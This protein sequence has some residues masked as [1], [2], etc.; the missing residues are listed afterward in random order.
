MLG[1]F[2]LV[3]YSRVHGILLLPRSQSS[4]SSFTIIM[5]TVSQD[6][7]LYSTNKYDLNLVTVS[8]PPFIIRIYALSL[9]GYTVFSSTALQYCTLGYG[10]VDHPC[11]VREPV[12]Y[13]GTFCVCNPERLSDDM[14]C[15]TSRNMNYKRI[16]W[17]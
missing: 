9:D 4:Y 7:M 12:G 14:L 13:H 11:E 6:R 1:L 8:N 5:S 17:L 15:S 10:V 2:F 3:V 16:R